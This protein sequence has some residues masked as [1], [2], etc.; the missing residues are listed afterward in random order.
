M[1]KKCSICRFACKIEETTDCKFYPQEQ[2]LGH[3]RYF[4]DLEPWK[5]HDKTSRMC[6]VCKDYFNYRN[7]V[8]K[9]E[10]E[11]LYPFCTECHKRGLFIDSM[12][13]ESY[14]R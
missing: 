6:V 3:A 1:T 7:I 10:K 12:V 5:K 9:R 11:G 13:G 8:W 4:K 14:S 2:H